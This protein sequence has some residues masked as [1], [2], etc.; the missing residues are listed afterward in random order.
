MNYTEAKDAIYKKAMDLE[1]HLQEV[2]PESEQRRQLIDLIEDVEQDYFN[3]VVIG[4]FKHGK[5]TFVN[6]LLGTD[7][8]PRDVTP[9]TAAINAVLYGEEEKVQLVKADGNTEEMELSK[10]SLQPFTV[11]G[12]Y[13]INDV[14]YLKLFLKSNLLK[15]RVV[16]VDTPGVNDLNE[17]RAQITYQFIPR[18]DV[19][20]FL[21]SMTNALKKTEQRFIE[22]YLMNGLDKTIF[23][24]NFLDRV[25]DDE[26]D[27]VMEH[28]ERRL[29]K[30]TNR[31]DISII[32]LSAKEALDGKL[33][34]DEELLEYSGMVDIEKA[35]QEQINS[36]LKGQT[37]INHF[38]DRLSQ[39]TEKIIGEIQTVN[40]LSMENAEELEAKLAYIREWKNNQSSMENH[41]THYIQ[42]REE[43]I[44]YIIE[45]SVTYFGN[46][47]QE[48]VR[49]RIHVYQGADVK[50][51]V[52][53]DLP[54]VIRSQFNQWVNQY[55][56][57]IYD[58]LRR[59][60]ME[61]SKGLS[62]SFKTNVHVHFQ[63]AGEIKFSNEILDL[64]YKTGNANVKAGFLMGGASSIAL[65]LGGGFF[66]PIV[67]MA[68]MPFLS[69]KIA[70]KQLENVKPEIMKGVSDQIDILLNDFQKHLDHFLHQEI[71]QIRETSINE[72]YRQ[73]Q[74]FQTIV[75]KQIEQKTAETN[76]I[77]E[78]QKKLASCESYIKEIILE[79]ELVNE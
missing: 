65:L 13:N 40:T 73:L 76:Q 63:H 42:E 4:E 8:M 68:G 62:N 38:N 50:T 29:Q 34:Q 55:S 45:K 74:S 2:L 37:K 56:D 1:Q 35:L 7:V 5:S 44:R 32:G 71:R 16:L 15:N 52:S 26:V 59:L 43:E 60:K 51:L 14:K 54:V 72:F 9:T 6:A 39:I 78:Y 33:K 10:E 70:E 19:V 77:K 3:V 28:M 25:D 24:A 66:L 69:Q 48:D 41:L 49:N 57:Y 67:G 12:G 46:G 79:E 18:A 17:H 20:I 22:D 64:N 58:L 53:S 11:E 21:T 30:I 23:A 61:I 27:D 47:L 36:G 31:R 75:D